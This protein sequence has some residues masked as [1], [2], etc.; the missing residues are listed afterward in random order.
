MKKTAS[1]LFCILLATAAMAQQETQYV[2]QDNRESSGLVMHPN[3][4]A[5]VV[6]IEHIRPV[7]EV[8]VFN[9]LGQVIE[10][11]ETNLN[12]NYVLDLTE[13]RNGMYFIRVTDELNNWY[14]QKVI[15]K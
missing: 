1:L 4:T 7:T 10:R 8:I 6:Y 15:K 3:P 12:Q 5:D 11:F 9:L 2:I 13:L 14:I